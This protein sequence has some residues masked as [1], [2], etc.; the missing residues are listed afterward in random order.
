[1]FGVMSTSRFN[2]YTNYRGEPLLEVVAMRLVKG[3]A[4]GLV[5]AVN[6]QDSSYNPAYRSLTSQ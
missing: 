5:R 3:A 1:M 6:A 4:G 2:N